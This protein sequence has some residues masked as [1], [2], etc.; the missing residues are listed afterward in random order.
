MIDT[1]RILRLLDEC[2]PGHA[3]P[4]AFYVDR[5]IFEFDLEAIHARSWMLAGFEV[6]VPEPGSTLALTIGRTPIVVV[7]GRDK[8][9]R[10]FYNICRH[11][12]SQI[13]AT[14]RARRP[15]MVCP[16][17]QW[18]YDLEGNLVHA[19][20]MGEDFD[21][22]AHG[23]RPIHLEAVAGAILVCL[24]DEP[25]D[26]AAFRAGLEPLLAPHRLENSKLA[27]ETTLVE[28]GNWKLAM[29]NARE[30]Y[31][32]LARHP[33]LSITFPVDGWRSSAS[34]PS[35]AQTEFAA[36]MKGVGL[37]VGPS[38]GPWWQAARFP[39]NDG[40]KSLTMDGKLAVKK[41]LLDAADGDVGSMRLAVE[42]HV[43]AHACGDSL[44]VFSAN[45]T[46]PEET[47]ITSK[48]FV[49]KDAVDGVDYTLDDLTKLWTLTN[50]EDRDLVENNQRGVDGRGFVP[51]PYAP[52]AESLVRR[53]TDW[54]R[55]KAR[56]YLEANG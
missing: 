16:Y 35:D 40:A 42:P 49:H 50:L 47:V 26:F 54:Y 25:P 4:R 44:F 55:G 31:H 38:D 29:E 7:R 33:E 14:G 41:R 48:W 2:K 9:L 8:K 21:R 28:R 23:L 18:A 46:A 56:A 11:R 17:H 5:D 39:L 36:R 20:Q 51:G 3:L 19:T 34:N 6:E 53:F 1:T 15:R 45:P 37:P 10:A 13:C 32:C 12:G 27:A 24:A 22:A 43:F 52:E 30:C